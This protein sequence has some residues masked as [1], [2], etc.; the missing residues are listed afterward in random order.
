[1]ILPNLILS[2]VTILGADAYPT[3]CG[4]ETAS[5]M[6]PIL[7]TR[8]RGKTYHGYAGTMPPT[9]IFQR[10]PGS[11][12][13]KPGAG[14]FNINLDSELILPGTKSVP[15]YCAKIL[16]SKSGMLEIFEA[17]CVYANYLSRGY[18]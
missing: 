7:F 16:P 17:I 6:S 4:N 1:M 15:R 14:P 9:G 11:G 18:A 3:V 8:F 12:L 13:P 10:L 5:R 2:V